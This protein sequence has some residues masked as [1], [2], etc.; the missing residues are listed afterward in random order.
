MPDNLDHWGEPKKE[1]TLPKAVLTVQDVQK[2]KEILKLIAEV[3]EFNGQWK[4][5]GKLAPERLDAL[6]KV[7]TV[8]NLSVLQPA[9]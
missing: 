4:A 9:Y 3:D 7:A 6:K 1:K 8:E 5:L 2:T